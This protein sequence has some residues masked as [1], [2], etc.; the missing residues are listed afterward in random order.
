[1]LKETLGDSYEMLCAHGLQV[2]AG[3]PHWFAL[4]F[5]TSIQRVCDTLEQVTAIYNYRTILH[6]YSASVADDVGG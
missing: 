5:L 1:M 3:T 6:L 2:G 4:E